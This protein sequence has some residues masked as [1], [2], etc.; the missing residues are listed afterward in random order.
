LRHLV[1]KTWCEVLRKHYRRA[2][3][4]KQNITRMSDLSPR[5][6]FSHKKWYTYQ[7]ITVVWCFKWI[8]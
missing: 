3:D 6:L 8:L 2:S 7:I 4:I 5:H 1:T